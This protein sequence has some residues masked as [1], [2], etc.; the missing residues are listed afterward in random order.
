MR[1]YATGNRAQEQPW[2][3]ITKLMFRIQFMEKVGHGN[4]KH[5]SSWPVKDR[6][7]LL[8]GYKKSQK[9]PVRL[10]ILALRA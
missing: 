6:K 8:K 10:S 9:T 2:L 4:G 3:F 7:V 5:C 1:D